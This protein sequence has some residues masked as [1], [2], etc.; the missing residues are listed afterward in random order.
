MAS[1]SRHGIYSAATWPRPR[2]DLEMRCDAFMIIII[3]TI[4]LVGGAVCNK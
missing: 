2:L 1:K 3:C 4:L